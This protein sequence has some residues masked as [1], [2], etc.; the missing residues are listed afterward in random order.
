MD[1]EY[2][3]GSE[4]EGE[5]PHDNN[6]N[7]YIYKCNKAEIPVKLR[8]DTINS[9]KC[10]T[11]ECEEASNVIR[12]KLDLNVNPCEDFYHFACGGWIKAKEKVLEQTDRDSWDNFGEVNSK[13]VNQ[14]EG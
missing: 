13:L 11:L 8:G 3:S 9:R 10:L 1:E 5:N 6:D 4:A 12:S 2:N 7:S 14:F